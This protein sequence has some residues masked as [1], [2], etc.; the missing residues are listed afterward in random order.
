MSCSNDENT[1]EEDAAILDNM[2]QKIVE[3]SQIN[4][5]KCTNPEE[6]AFMKFGESSCAGYI[7][8]NK[9]IN[10]A[11]FEKEIK[12]YNTATAKFEEKWGI[13]NDFFPCVAKPHT[14][15]VLCIEEKPTLDIKYS[16]TS[17]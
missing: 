13:V 2:Y 6:W 15:S 14:V 8:Y 1:M 7:I 3:N 9:S 10:V 5:K 11:N 16:T 4:S 17:K 12:Q